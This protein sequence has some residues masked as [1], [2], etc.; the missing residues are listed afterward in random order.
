M[1]GLTAI[2]APIAVAMG[3]AMVGAATAAG[4]EG[5]EKLFH[6]EVCGWLYELQQSRS[7]AR[8]GRP[9]ESE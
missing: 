7:R 2:P 3:K 5:V 4:A 8:P 6:A 1:R 9:T